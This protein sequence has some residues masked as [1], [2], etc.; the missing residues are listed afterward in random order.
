[1]AQVVIFVPGGVDVDAGVKAL[2]KAGHDVEVIEA[3]P[4]ALLHMA[5]GM[6]EGDSGS[7]QGASE[8]E[9]E[10]KKEA[11]ETADTEE[12]PVEE[13]VKE[14]FLGNVTIDGE[15]V[16][17]YIGERDQIFAES[18]SKMADGLSF[19]IN[20]SSYNLRSRKTVAPFIIAKEGK[21]VALD[22]EIKPSKNSS[23]VVLSI[24]S[25]QK[26]GF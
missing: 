4:V 13:P 24:D 19:K 3:D 7:S 8:K 9:D 14:Q 5:I 12:E 2:E 6:L 10:E 11:E 15:A 23:F 21:Q 20:E 17:A 16:P 26:L 25:A 22:S 1:M 18:F